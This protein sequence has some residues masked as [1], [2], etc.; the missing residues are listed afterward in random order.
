MLVVGG[1]AAHLT[2]R[3]V[4]ARAL[5]VFAVL[6][7]VATVVGGCDHVRGVAAPGHHSRGRDRGY[8]RPGLSH[9]RAGNVR[10]R[11]AGRAMIT[12]VCALALGLLLDGSDLADRWR[13]RQSERARIAA[14]LD[15]FQWL[16]LEDLADAR[17]T[18]LCRDR[19]SGHE[20][21]QW[22]HDFLE[23]EGMPS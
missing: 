21:I 19:A 12:A 4:A 6:A 16:V 10:G 20:E 15:R 3:A 7:F 8:L 5:W 22:R 13:T 14:G 23:H 18:F 2:H 11:Q 1:S 9:Q 17:Q